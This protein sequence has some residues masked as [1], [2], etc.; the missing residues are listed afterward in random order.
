MVAIGVPG[1]DILPNIARYAAEVG[2]VGHALIVCHLENQLH[3]FTS[4]YYLSMEDDVIYIQF[5]WSFSLQF[6]D[7]FWCFA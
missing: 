2:L 4:M 6:Y 3:S 7:W 1:L 5:T